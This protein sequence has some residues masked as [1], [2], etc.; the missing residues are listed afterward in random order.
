[1]IGLAGGTKQDAVWYVLAF[2]GLC[3]A[4]D[5]GARRT[6]GLRGY[7][8][9][10]L[11]RDGKW[12]LL[13]LGVIP[14]VTYVLTW[15]NWLVT[16]TGYDRNYAQGTGFNIPVLGPLYS[17]FNYH[18]QIFQFMDGLSTRHPYESQ[19]WDWFFITRP[20]AFYWTSYTDS[21]GLHAAEGGH[22]RAVGAGSAGD[23]QPRHL[24]GVHPRDGRLPR[25]VADPPGLA[26]GRRAA[27]RGRRA[28]R[29]GCRS[30]RGPSSTTTRSSSSRS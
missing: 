7:V 25:L 30:S 8:R 24:V 17:L 22:D 2:I 19:P 15:T 13:T 3:L 6:A 18:E 21:A 1:M 9:G 27:R 5:I 23:R 16:S 11:V 28:G 10:A 4:W 14:L 12:L 29:P 20:V 26:G